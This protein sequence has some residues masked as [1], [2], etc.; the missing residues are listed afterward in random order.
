[1]ATDDVRRSDLDL[2]EDVGEDED[3]DENEEDPTGNLGDE[4]QLRG[5]E[6]GPGAGAPDRPGA[7]GH[8]HPVA[9]IRDFG[10]TTGYDLG[11][12]SPAARPLAAG[13]R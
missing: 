2:D 10:A 13:A 8:G 9:G 3:E 12:D 6:A 11:R 1:M 7:P 5:P 4:R